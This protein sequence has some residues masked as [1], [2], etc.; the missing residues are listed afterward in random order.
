MGMS[1]R[2]A[3]RE[4][5]YEK[6]RTIAGARGTDGPVSTTYSAS[7]RR[8]PHLLTRSRDDMRG[9]DRDSSTSWAKPKG[10]LGNFA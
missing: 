9:L 6:Y 5:S 10:A 4:G 7:R 3:L 8:I 2:C 1:S